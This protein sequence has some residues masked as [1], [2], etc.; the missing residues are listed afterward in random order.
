M[1]RGL[2]A[3]LAAVA[4]C[5]AAPA[6]AIAAEPGQADLPAE[7]E[8]WA[9]DVAAVACD[10]AARLRGAV[11]FPGAELATVEDE[12][13]VAVAQVG[14]G[15]EPLLPGE[16]L[17]L[18]VTAPSPTAVLLVRVASG[19]RDRR[20]TIVLDRLV[21]G[22]TVAVSES[23]DVSVTRGSE[24]VALGPPVPD[25]PPPPPAGTPQ[26][27]AARV[28]HGIATLF[29]P[30]APGFKEICN[31]LDPAARPYFD[32]SLGDPELYPCS[33]L[34]YLFTVG[35]ENVPTAFASSAKLTSVRMTGR[36]EALLTADLVYRYKPYSTG[37]RRRIALRARALLRRVGDGSWRLA[38]PRSL[39]ALAATRGPFLT[40]P[41]LAKLRGR[42]A[43]L[44][45][46]ARR[47]RR[48]A[49]A[50]DR[51]RRAASRPVGGPATC[52]SGVGSTAVDPTGDANV[53]G[54]QVRTRLPALGATVDIV[55]ASL[56]MR[57]GGPPCMV[58]DFAQPV[59]LGT[60]LDIVFDTLTS[61]HN[62]QSSTSATVHIQAGTVLATDGDSD[63]VHFF[64]GARAVAQG[65]RLVVRLAPAQWNGAL[66]RRTITWTVH[67]VRP[68]PYAITI[69]DFTGG[70]RRRPAA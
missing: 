38:D 49:A 6:A 4:L 24:V 69:E 50:L 51:R 54:S 25:E 15:R 64:R 8:T 61:N 34:M 56:V 66:L 65:N 1:P 16:R 23:L 36:S 37:D 9:G 35:D 58:L 60:P 13:D 17:T 11:S 18:S 27:V 59:D 3:G 5:G 46:D 31:T 67:A 28:V 47:A 12:G 32:L 42:A 39:L 33:T 22:M 14:G 2:L 21:D 52:P 45:A 10:P 48:A 63:D 29:V 53:D 70:R 7:C 68:H 62:G 41:A 30:R 55:G 19:R 26:E 44:R 43:N 40:A 57:R 20:R